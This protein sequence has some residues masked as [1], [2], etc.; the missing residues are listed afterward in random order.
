[1]YAAFLTS[2]SPD[3]KCRNCFSRRDNERFRDRKG[4]FGVKD[5]EIA[6][7]HP[8]KHFPSSLTFSFY[9]CPVTVGDMSYRKWLDSYVEYKSGKVPYKGG[10]MDH[11]AKFYEAMDLLDNFNIEN[12][13]INRER[14]DSRRGKR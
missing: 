8:T 1:M 11:P 5:Y 7:R 3:L 2:I 14:K 4:C 10:Y 12:D 6:K 9:K 13:S